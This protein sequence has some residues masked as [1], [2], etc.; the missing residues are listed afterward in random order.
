MIN[1]NFRK[2]AED[3]GKIAAKGFDMVGKELIGGV[4]ELKKALDLQ[5]E[6]EDKMLDKMDDAEIRLRLQEHGFAPIDS[7]VIDMMAPENKV[8]F[9]STLY[10]LVDADEAK[11]TAEYFGIAVVKFGV[12]QI[13][14]NL[15]EKMEDLLGRLNKAESELLMRMVCEMVAI[16]NNS[17]S[18]LDVSEVISECLLVTDKK[19]QQIKADVKKLANVGV[20]VFTLLLA[21]ECAPITD[22]TSSVS[23]DDEGYDNCERFSGFSGGKKKF[24]GIDIVFSDR[25]SVS[26]TSIIFENCTL[27]FDSEFSHIVEVSNGDIQFVGC[28]FVSKQRINGKAF[29]FEDVDVSLRFCSFEN[30]TSGL[31]ASMSGGGLCVDEC[32]FLS[33]EC[34]IIS[35]EELT[36][37]TFNKCRIEKQKD[38]LASLYLAENT[39]LHVN[40]CYFVECH[41]SSGSMLNSFTNISINKS[42]FIK[43]GMNIAN[44]W[45]VEFQHCI[46]DSCHGDMI[47][48]FFPRTI[49]FLHCDITGHNG[50]LGTA[51]VTSS[52]II[53]K[54][55]KFKNINGSFIAES[56]DITNSSFENCQGDMSGHGINTENFLYINEEFAFNE[57]NT[58][59]PTGSLIEVKPKK[60]SEKTSINN[61]KFIECK[62]NGALIVAFSNDK[63]STIASI[64]DCEIVNCQCAEGYLLGVHVKDSKFFLAPKVIDYWKIDVDLFDTENI[65][66]LCSVL[67]K[68][69]TNGLVKGCDK[70]HKAPVEYKIEKNIRESVMNDS[71]DDVFTMYDDSIMGKGKSGLVF[72]YRSIYFSQMMESNYSIPYE[73]IALIKNMSID[74]KEYGDNY[75]ATLNIELGNGRY[76]I[77]KDPYFEK[78][79]L[80]KVLDSIR[81]VFN[82][83]K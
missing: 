54:S 43:S 33:C 17:S 47:P 64:N 49:K 40:D 45:E 70:F 37:V 39:P 35:A 56:F 57:F 6:F 11:L 30:W 26:N 42:T 60:E 44:A 79:E 9:I 18:V 75:D 2:G 52:H 23:V 61:C 46:F 62:A 68:T 53:I 3:V 19:K 21:S 51:F 78:K 27:V 63:N 38:N 66:L 41:Y 34:E 74:Y 28:K 55:C 29:V 14:D 16:S 12:R 73:K 10:L 59:L 32:F 67:R 65:K 36:G 13:R 58:M 22:D 81:N 20:S 82:Q 1:K 72:G 5:S 76:I 71:S 31:F 25:Y 50:N 83:K 15:S 77:F 4:G 8:V 48:T 7:T 80:I 69:L 24:A